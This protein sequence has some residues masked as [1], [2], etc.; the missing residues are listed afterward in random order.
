MLALRL[1]GACPYKYFLNSLVFQEQGLTASG[2]PFFKAQG[3]DVYM[4]HDLDCS[5]DGQRPARWIINAVPPKA[6]R[7]QDLDQDGSCKYHARLDSEDR[8][9]PAVSA[10][11][12][13]F[14]GHAWSNLPMQLSHVAEHASDVEVV[15]APR[16]VGPAHTLLLK[17]NFCASKMFFEGMQFELAGATASGAPYYR[18]AELDQYVYY[19]PSCNGEAG[20]TA[21][22]VIDVDAPDLIRNS[23]LDGDAACNY[24]AR[25]ESD[26]H[27]MPPTA[28]MWR[29]YCDGSWQ[30]LWLTLESRPMRSTTSPPAESVLSGAEGYPNNA[31]MLF[32]LLGSLLLGS[33]R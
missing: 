10:M 1:S 3:I 7:L 29:V 25:A 16:P 4:Y 32:L 19:D 5:G 24:H 22:W 17:G 20:A 30:D 23:D 31:G 21:R 11:W 13:V 8:T 28:A 15:T 6:S 9:G 26:D 27:L 2:A 14:C 12:R 33:L 18:A